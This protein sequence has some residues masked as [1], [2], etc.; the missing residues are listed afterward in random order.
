M[1]SVFTQPRLVLIWFL[2]P[3]VI[4]T[5]KENS[6]GGGGGISQMRRPS[7]C[8]TSNV[9]LRS[10]RT[11]L[12]PAKALTLRG[13]RK[14]FLLSGRFPTWKS[15][16]CPDDVKTQLPLPSPGFLCFQIYVSGTEKY[17]FIRHS[18]INWEVLVSP[19]SKAL[20]QTGQQNMT[21]SLSPASAKPLHLCHRRDEDFLRTGQNG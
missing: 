4:K 17:S 16:F 8:V 20:F 1:G 3:W 11:N 18:H 6:I 12:K 13:K 2:N 9:I 10:K 19:D 7:E 5:A 21:F 14:L 15:S